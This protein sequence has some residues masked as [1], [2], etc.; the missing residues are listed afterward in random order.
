ME[1]FAAV[2]RAPL[3]GIRAFEASRPRRPLPS[4][5]LDAEAPCYSSR[6]HP[7]L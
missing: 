1:S 2:V 4:S 6:Y 5:T 7:A 3:T